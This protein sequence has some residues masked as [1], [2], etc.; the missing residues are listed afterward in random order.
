MSGG[1]KL[2]IQKFIVRRPI[3]IIDLY[4]VL[5]IKNI[6]Q[7]M[8]CIIKCCDFTTLNDKLIV[9][10]NN[11]D[12]KAQKSKNKIIEYLPTFIFCSIFHNII[13]IM[14]KCTKLK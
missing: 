9:I 4:K 13:N 10:Q 6:L 2:R 8:A 11:D 14:N 5:T 3:I 1:N 7:H 12:K